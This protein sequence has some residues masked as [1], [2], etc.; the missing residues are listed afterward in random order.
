M[1]VVGANRV[2]GVEV[3]IGRHSDG[4]SDDSDRPADGKDGTPGGGASFRSSAVQ[5][6]A[7]LHH[8]YNRSVRTHLTSGQRRLGLRFLS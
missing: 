2:L 3:N 8:V 7:F 5:V 6:N 1:P 4:P